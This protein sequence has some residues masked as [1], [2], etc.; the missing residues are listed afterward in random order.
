VEIVRRS[1]EAWNAGAMEALRECYD[2]DV[3]ITVGPEGWAEGEDPIVGI[4]AVMRLFASLRKTWDTD[5]MEPV[6]FT[7]AGDR[8]VVHHVWRAKGRGPD[9]DIE[10]GV[11]CTLRDRR[12]C[13]VQ[14]FWG[15]DEARKAVGLI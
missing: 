13:L 12:I 10:Q 5:A 8:V 7:E 9:L 2:P 14:A 4:D 6:G 15:H 1:Y 11:V 3:M